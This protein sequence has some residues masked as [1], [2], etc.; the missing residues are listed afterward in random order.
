MNYLLDTCV[1][2]EFT[3][4]APSKHVMR[5]MECQDER[6]LFICSITWGELHK[7]VAKLYQSR[8]KSELTGWLGQLRESFGPRNLAYTSEVSEQWALMLTDMEKR[9]K[10]MPLMDSMIAATARYYQLT[11]VTRNT[12]DFVNTQLLMV[13]PWEC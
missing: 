9:G 4:R 7:G 5:W 12:N 8:R 6:A 11:L 2:S 3:K 10:P 13:N 1:L